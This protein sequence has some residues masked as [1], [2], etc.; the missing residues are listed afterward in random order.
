MFNFNRSFV[1]L[2]ESPSIVSTGVWNY[3]W[4]RWTAVFKEVLI[5]RGRKHRES[6]SVGPAYCMPPFILLITAKKNV[7]YPDVHMHRRCNKLFRFVKA[8][9]THELLVQDSMRRLSI[10]CSY[11]HLTLFPFVTSS[12]TEGDW[13]NSARRNSHSHSAFAA[14][15]NYYP[16]YP[17]IRIHCRP[18]VCYHTNSWNTDFHIVWICIQIFPYNEALRFVTPLGRS[19]KTRWDWN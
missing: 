5:V 15:G 8:N 17:T 9:L 12:S 7:K 3:L 2:V 10:L 6:I 11:F 14:L 18:G 16:I 1:L 13:R 4:S 19:R